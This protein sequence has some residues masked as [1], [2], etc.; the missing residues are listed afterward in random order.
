MPTRESSIS[1][2]KITASEER[3]PAKVLGSS[4][5][6]TE[7]RPSVVTCTLPASPDA[8]H[9]YTRRC[10][11]A[12]TNTKALTWGGQGSNPRPTDY[13]IEDRTQF[14]LLPVYACGT[15]M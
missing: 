10:H 3:T 2:F 12:P 8:E 11:S 15:T 4:A 13:Q 14:R 7:S 9:H 6:K 5:S 1:W